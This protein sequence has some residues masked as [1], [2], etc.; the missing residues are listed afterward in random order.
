M[1]K[2]RYLRPTFFID[3]DAAAVREKS[4]AIVAPIKGE[5]EQAVSLFSF[6]R[7]EIRYNAF[8]PRSTDGHY[9][10]S[11]ILAV[12][13]GYCVQKAVLLVALARAAAIPA[14]LRFADIRNHLAPEGFVE[15][16]G[17]NLFSYHGLA[18]LRIDGRWIKATP[19]YDQGFCRKT[20][21]SPVLFDGSRDAMLPARALDGR[22]YV[23]YILDRGFF[24]DLPLEEMRKASSSWKYLTP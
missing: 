18:D 16:R 11:H 14:R 17:S 4:Q 9:K 21:V 19:T 15:K 2:D 8:S 7:D 22:P 13:E 10:A 5:R 24:D 1:G 3:C 12:G 6:V 20:G 23:D